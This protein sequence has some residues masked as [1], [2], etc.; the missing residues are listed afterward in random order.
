MTRKLL[1]APFAAPGATDRLLRAALDE[2]PGPDFRDILYLCP[3]PRKLR[4]TQQRFPEISGLS[5]CYPPQFST[6]AQYARLLH[7]RHGEA[8]RFPSELRPLLVRR[9]LA[10]GAPSRTLGYARA[11]ADFIRD[12]RTWVPDRSGL[13]QVF[14]DELAGFEQPLARALEALDLL[15]RYEKE[16]HAHGLCDDE[17]VWTSAA[18]LVPGTGTPKV[19]VLDGFA[20]PNPLEQLLLAA[21]IEASGS[22]FAS[23]FAG[24]DQD[25]D[26]AL[27]TG[28]RLFL[29]GLGGFATETLEP[30]PVLEPGGLHRFP[31]PEGEIGGICRYL[32]SQD[33]LADTVVALPDLEARA[34]MVRRVFEQY[35]LP[36]TTFPQ[37]KLGCSGP[38]ADVLELLRAL[39][40]GFERLPT[41]AAFSSPF[42]P[43]LLRLPGD[44]G[45]AERE[46]A[47]AAL[48][49]LSRKAGI[50]KGRK[51]WHH[52]RDRLAAGERDMDDAMA[53][54]LK[55]VETRVRQALG[56][57]EYILEPTG[58]AGRQAAKL[59][60]FLEAVDFCRNRPGAADARSSLYDV[61][62]GLAGF[63]AVF[64]AETASRSEFVRTLE[65]LAG[66]CRAGSDPSPAGV[67]VLALGPET[68]G[69]H[70]RRVICAGLT[71]TNLPGNYRRDPI[72]PERLLRRLGMPD[73]DWHRDWQRF[74]LRRTIE[75]ATGEVFLSFHDSDDSKP[76]L[77]TPLLQL[78]P[79]SPPPAEVVFSP[80]EQQLDTGRRTG[81]PFAETGRAVDYVRDLEVRKVLGRRF[82][83]ERALSVTGIEAYRRCPHRFYL[84]RVLGLETPPEP[85]FEIDASRWG[86]VIH[87]CLHL[88]YEKGPVPLTELA[89]RARAALDVALREYELPAFWSEMT[90]RV[91]DNFMPRFEEIEKEERDRGFLPNRT[92]HTLEGEVA[93]GI[94][95]R[96]RLD[97]L[98]ESKDAVRIIDYKT[99]SAGIRPKQV[100]VDRTHVQLP[101]YCR[102]VE[103]PS[104]RKVDNCGIYTTR[105]P[106]IRWLADGKHPLAELVEAALETTVEAV[107]AIRR[108]EFPA[109]PAPGTD[110]SKC[111]YAYLCARQ[112]EESG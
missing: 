83:P 51:D 47:A 45:P 66:S 101:L 34:P 93:D 40:T 112:D 32:R 11:V 5:A 2:V 13:R 78:E 12:I 29:D 96:G 108:G 30:G 70:P 85:Q 15:E 92:E 89:D 9:L 16:L 61:L 80:V 106:A 111:E 77:P 84:E 94:R 98:D 103:E 25:P 81:T 21:L 62:D 65:Y 52:I 71:E 109:R 102:L 36:V 97:R 88:L 27:G 67:L 60:Q 55:D 63:D 28:F 59:K 42:L 53:G 24:D 57:A 3:S 100:T 68:L 1:L 44:T 50:I 19:L 72:L 31:D 22:V 74:H 48:D 110:C 20:S 23:C 54:F 79:V 64:G 73:M 43:G 10:P 95:I 37:A 75:S 7:D 82:G 99:G 35:G 41:A 6:P 18:R 4:D 87:R 17:D 105:E 76:V 26:Y 91:F 69:L 58:P 46:R 56:L 14:E 38:V 49:Y 33:D 86:L 104:G 90:R 39:D 107:E 8:T